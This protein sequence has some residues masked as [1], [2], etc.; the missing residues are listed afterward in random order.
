MGAVPLAVVDET[1]EPSYHAV[2]VE[3]NESV[4]GFVGNSGRI[5]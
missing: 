5:L 4:S 3:S 2:F 1:L